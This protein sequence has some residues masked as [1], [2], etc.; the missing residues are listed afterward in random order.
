M[1]SMQNAFL[2]DEFRGFFA[3]FIFSPF[4]LLPNEKK[5]DILIGNSKFQTQRGVFYV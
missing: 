4:A 3:I 2:F 1:M 5:C